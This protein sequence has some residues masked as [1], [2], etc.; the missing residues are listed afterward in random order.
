[1]KNLSRI[2]GDHPFVETCSKDTSLSDI[3]QKGSASKM[4]NR[5][6]C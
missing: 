5:D 2:S 3:V 6:D 4:K 1:M